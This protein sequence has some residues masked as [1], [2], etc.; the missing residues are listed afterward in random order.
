MTTNEQKR[1]YGFPPDLT[2]PEIVSRLFELLNHRPP[3]G[4]VAPI[5]GR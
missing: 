2:E 5:R 4:V 1:S 3:D